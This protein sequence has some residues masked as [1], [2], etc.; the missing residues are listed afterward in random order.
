MPQAAIAIET[1]RFN[2]KQVFTGPTSLA[3]AAWLA[4]LIGIIAIFMSNSGISDEQL[5]WILEEHSHGYQQPAV[6]APEEP[7]PSETPPAPE[8]EPP[9]LEA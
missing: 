1:A 9:V 2:F 7:T 5:G 6:P 4:I 3:T 8:Q